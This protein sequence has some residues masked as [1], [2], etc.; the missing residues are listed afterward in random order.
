MHALN[1][2]PVWNVVAWSIPGVLVGS[3]IGSKL[4]KYLPAK[5]MEKGLGVAFAL[6]GLL[7]LG[8]EFG[9]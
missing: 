3:T 6:V 8:L 9:K 5:L 4:G 7:V 2:T 1:A